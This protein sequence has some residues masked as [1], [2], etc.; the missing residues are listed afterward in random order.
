MINIKCHRIRW[1]SQF[2]NKEL[3]LWVV[4]VKFMVVLII[5]LINSWKL[6][7]PNKKTLQLWGQ[8][9]ASSLFQKVC[10]WVEKFTQLRKWW[11][12]DSVSFPQLYRA[13]QI[14]HVYSRLKQHGNGSFHVVSLCNTRGVFVGRAQE[15]L[16]FSTYAF[17][18]TEF[19][20]RTSLF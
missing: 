2:E 19:N 14:H 1:S 15:V 8:T 4:Q 9:R 12:V 10:L 16:K 7:L 20:S 17:Y 18:M 5:F 13:L 3:K 11:V 6:G